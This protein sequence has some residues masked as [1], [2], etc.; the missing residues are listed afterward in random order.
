MTDLHLTDEQ[1]R[2]SYVAGRKLRARLDAIRADTADR[3]DASA[4]AD[5]AESID[6][7][8]WKDGACTRVCEVS[9]RAPDGSMTRTDAC[10]CIRING[11]RVDEYGDPKLNVEPCN[12]CD[13]APRTKK[14]NTTMSTRTDANDLD[15]DLDAMVRLDRS[16]DDPN[17]P[18]VKARRDRDQRTHLEGR[19]APVSRADADEEQ[20]SA[21]KARR[22]A[23]R[24]RCGDPAIT[25]REVD[26]VIR[27]RGGDQDLD[28]MSAPGLTQ[29]IADA[30][31]RIAD[32]DKLGAVGKDPANLDSLGDDC[33]ISRAR[34]ERD[35]ASRDAWKGDR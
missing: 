27:M 1:W 25:K 9:G 3:L 11:V 29:L 32:M 13:L 16:P 33:A 8:A 24:V 28:G 21:R 22:D 14:E 23:L 35:I 15:N 18:V 12:S 6:P 7:D 4:F 20:Q 19:T 17:D 34:R 26:E 30:R 5:A 31:K 2:A 10:S